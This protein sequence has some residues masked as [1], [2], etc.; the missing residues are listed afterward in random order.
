MNWHGLIEYIVDR[1]DERSTWVW[2]ISVVGS[3]TG[4][5]FDPERAEEISAAGATLGMLFGILLA[6]SGGVIRKSGDVPEHNE[7]AESD[8]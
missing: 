7:H 8:G 2:I 6:D 1:L 3:M 4:I 5:A